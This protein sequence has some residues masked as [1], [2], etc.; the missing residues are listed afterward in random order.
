MPVTIKRL[1]RAD[2]YVAVSYTHLDVY[3]R[4]IPTGSLA[5]VGLSVYDQ[6][7]GGPLDEFDAA[8]T[9]GARLAAGFA[10]GGG[11]D[12][13]QAEVASGVAAAGGRAVG[14][15]AVAGLALW[16]LSAGGVA[17]RVGALVDVAARRERRAACLLYTSRCV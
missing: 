6:C 16:A 4:Q 17:F 1:E 11:R 8:F 10:G 12:L 3:K 7:E 15:R 5:D 9:P 13:V 14:W 2:N